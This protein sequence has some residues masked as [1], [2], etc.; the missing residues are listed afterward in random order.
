MAKDGGWVIMEKECSDL[1]LIGRCSV[2]V[3]CT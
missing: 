3:E 2:F 1:L